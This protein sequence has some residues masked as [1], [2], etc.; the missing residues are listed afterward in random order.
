MYKIYNVTILPYYF[1][2]SRQRPSYST[3][4]K[5]G[6]R[7]NLFIF[8][9]TKKN[10]WTLADGGVLNLQVDKL[11]KIYM[12][13]NFINSYGYHLYMKYISFSLLLYLLCINYFF[14]HS[15]FASKEPNEKPLV[16]QKLVFVAA[17]VFWM[18]AL[19]LGET[20]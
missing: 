9:S 15:W 8:L 6:T 10:D 3:T 11:D 17:A 18:A 2:I 16:L 12:K 5:K 19:L 13:N 7:L 20:V 1:I 14:G 4:T